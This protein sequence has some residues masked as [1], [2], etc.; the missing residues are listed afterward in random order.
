[1]DSSTRPQKSRQNIFLKNCKHNSCSCACQH[2]KNNSKAGEL[3]TTCLKHEVWTR[4]KI[5]LNHALQEEKEWSKK[6]DKASFY[7]PGKK[8]E[9]TVSGKPIQPQ[10]LGTKPGNMQSHDKERILYSFTKNM[11]LRNPFIQQKQILRYFQLQTSSSPKSR[12]AESESFPE[13]E[14]LLLQILFCSTF[15]EKITGQVAA[16]QI[17]SADN[18]Y[19]IKKY[20]SHLQKKRDPKS[21]RRLQDF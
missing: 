8:P 16:L 19:W 4:S 20:M 2:S 7:Y 3:V 11:P 10:K 17:L 6:K 15:V 12:K 18:K 14:L 9:L 5:I 21:L 13:I 1:M